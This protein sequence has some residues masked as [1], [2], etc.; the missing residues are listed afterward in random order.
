MDPRVTSIAEGALRRMGEPAR[1]TPEGALRLGTPSLSQLSNLAALRLEDPVVARVVQA[2]RDGTPVVLDRRRVE[3][4]L[5]F[6]SYPPRLREQFGRWFSRISAMGV[7]LVGPDG[8]EAAG[9]PPSPPSRDPLPPR[10]AQ[11][12]PTAPPAR[13]ERRVF[14]A[15]LGA[16][17]PVPRP[18]L[19]EPDK[20][21]ANC[22]GRCETLGF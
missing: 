13:P 7:A 18:C 6:E 21:C 14:E 3:S 20:P 17:D 8:P 1:R 2:L 10:A 22:S 11:E 5:H 9:P 4:E 12:V 15:V 19:L 16:V